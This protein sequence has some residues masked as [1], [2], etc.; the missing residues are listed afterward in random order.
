MSRDFALSVYDS[1]HRAGHDLSRFGLGRC[2]FTSYTPKEHHDFGPVL[3]RGVGDWTNNCVPACASVFLPETAVDAAGARRLLVQA[4]RDKHVP[5]GGAAPPWYTSSYAAVPVVALSYLMSASR[6]SAFLVVSSTSGTCPPVPRPTHAPPTRAPPASHS[7]PTRAPPAPHP[8]PAHA[9]SASDTL[10]LFGIGEQVRTDEASALSLFWDGVRP[11]ACLHQFHLS[12]RMV[13]HAQ[14]STR[15]TKIRWCGHLEDHEPAQLW[16]A[17]GDAVGGDSQ[18]ERPSA[19]PLG[20]SGPV[21]LYVDRWLRLPM[22][23]LLRRHPWAST[24]LTL[25]GLATHVHAVVSSGKAPDVGY[26]VVFGP[27]V[28]GRGTFVVAPAVL[29][30]FCGLQVAPHS[31]PTLPAL[32]ML[33][34]SSFGLLAAFRDAFLAGEL[35]VA[36]DNADAVLL[37]LAGMSPVRSNHR[38]VDVAS[39]TVRDEEV[40]WVVGQR[41]PESAAPVRKLACAFNCGGKCTV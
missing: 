21:S 31:V 26:Q 22:D 10:L 4:H 14:P 1:Y 8:D 3:G 30:V 23:Q 6:V 13:G 11:V 37:G 32:H 27:S 24:T 33:Q 12:V 28:G 20:F 41:S 25:P 15:R 38:Q 35:V 18:G 16:Y 17:A 39:V 5:R 36:S 29:A 2:D 7:R 34:W 40:Q 9:H 19:P